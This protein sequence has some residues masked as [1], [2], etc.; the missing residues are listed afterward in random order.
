MHRIIG[1]IGRFTQWLVTVVAL[2]LLIAHTV[3]WAAIEV[4]GTTLALLGLI[5]VIPVSEYITKIRLGSFEAEIQPREVAEVRTKASEAAGEPPPST[6]TSSFEAELL[7]LVKSDSQLGLAK[8]RIEIERAL[9]SIYDQAVPKPQSRPSIRHMLDAIQRRVQLPR[10][11]ASALVEV[12]GLAN[13]VVHG[14]YIRE[15][16]AESV[17]RMGAN[18]VS[19]LQEFYVKRILE[20]VESKAISQEELNQWHEAQYRVTTIV[21]LL[22]EPKMNIREL[23]QS[24]L[25][26]LLD[27]YNEYA[28]FLVGP[29][30]GTLQTL[31]PRKPQKSWIFWRRHK[32]WCKNGFWPPALIW[33]AT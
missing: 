17:A 33:E 1:E 23:N 21:P 16:D 9:R 13:R 29:N 20:P 3:K 14:E 15:E 6:K 28:E 4:D 27:G 10:D 11:L 30:F 24:S 19:R 18:L 12:V 26:E 31:P 2:C 22:D 7:A 25:N 8:V 32:M 5:I